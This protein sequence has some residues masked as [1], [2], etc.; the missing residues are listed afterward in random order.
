MAMV[1]L[2]LSLLSLL[3]LL[4]QATVTLLSLLLR[5]TTMVTLSLTG[6]GGRYQTLACEPSQYLRRDFRWNGRSHRQW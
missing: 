1:T 2:S 3:S 6:M 5:V 4:L